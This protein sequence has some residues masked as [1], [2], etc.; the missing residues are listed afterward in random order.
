MPIDSPWLYQ[1]FVTKRPLLYQGFVTKG[2]LFSIYF[3]LQ[4]QVDHSFNGLG[5]RPFGRAGEGV[6]PG[7]AGA[8]MEPLGKDFCT[9]S[10]FPAQ[11]V[12]L[13]HVSRRLT[14]RAFFPLF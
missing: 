10:Y 2:H 1:G 5:A 4:Y 9:P 3:R 6:W 13:A 7:F 12:Y 11:T 14:G 8:W